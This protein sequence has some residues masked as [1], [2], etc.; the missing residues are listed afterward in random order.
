MNKS[1]DGWIDKPKLLTRRFVNCAVH[2]IGLNVDTY[3]GKH[4]V[5]VL[6][7]K[8]NETKLHK[9]SPQGDVFEHLIG[10]KW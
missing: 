9:T 4:N 5:H 10:P 1:D 8:W 6:H 2:G 7:K 3:W